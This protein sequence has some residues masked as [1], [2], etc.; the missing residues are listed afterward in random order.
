MESALAPADDGKVRLS[1]RLDSYEMAEAEDAAYR[2][3]VRQVRLPGFRP[4][5]APRK[6]LEARLGVGYIRAEAMQDALGDYYRQAVVRHDV[7]VIAPPEIDITA[8]RDDG[9]VT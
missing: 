7:D 3:I 6:V 2:R 1:I 4:G 5:R 8:G 9:P